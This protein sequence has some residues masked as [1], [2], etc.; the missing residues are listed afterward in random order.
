MS[1]IDDMQWLTQSVGWIRCNG[2][3]TFQTVDGGKSWSP[4]EVADNQWSSLSVVEATNFFFMNS[5]SYVV[6]VQG[7]RWSKT[8]F[9]SKTPL[10]RSLQFLDDETGWAVYSE[11]SDKRV[12]YVRTAD[13]GHTWQNMEGAEAAKLVNLRFGSQLVGYGYSTDRPFVSRD[14]G[15]T[16]DAG[17]VSGEFTWPDKLFVL[18][19][20]TA[21][22]VGQSLCATSDTGVH[23]VCREIPASIPSFRIEGIFFRD[24]KTGWILSDD[25]LFETNNQ[26]ETWRQVRLPN[27]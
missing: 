5:D 23:W 17:E 3:G 13:G 26:G 24:R 25:Q 15:R 19:E 10:L 20:S 22:M 21:L 6:H 14:S 27:D 12:V 11:L 8:P 2:T 4:L 9:I 7:S 16:W 18:N 1:T